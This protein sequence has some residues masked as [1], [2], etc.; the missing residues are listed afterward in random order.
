MMVIIKPPS[1]VRAAQILFF[2]NAIV[3]LLLG[4]YTVA[5]L[6]S[7]ATEPSVTMW[8]VG[9][10]VFGNACAMLLAGIGIGRPRRLFFLVDMA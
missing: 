8:V 7:G 10:L 9:I 5:R 2:L 1:K 6:A 3:W 4:G